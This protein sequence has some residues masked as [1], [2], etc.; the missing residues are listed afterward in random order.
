M[1]NGD[2]VEHLLPCGSGLLLGS[3]ATFGNNYGKR[4]YRIFWLYGAETLLLSKFLNGFMDPLR[5]KS[6]PSSIKTI[7][8]LLKN[9]QVW[10]GLTHK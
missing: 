7:R 5:F 2:D 4:W 9:I 8:Q 6:W 3:E 1:A 10:T